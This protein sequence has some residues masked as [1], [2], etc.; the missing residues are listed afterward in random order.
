MADFDSLEAQL[1][2]IDSRLD[3]LEAKIE[4]ERTIKRICTTCRGAGEL[5][6]WDDDSPDPKYST[7][8]LCGG[9]MKIDWGVQEAL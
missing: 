9:A 4:S 1:D 2:A 6:Y 7:C 8:P 5:E 3:D